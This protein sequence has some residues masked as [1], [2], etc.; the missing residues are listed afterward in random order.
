M[1]P[2]VPRL[3]YGEWSARNARLGDIHLEWAILAVKGVGGD[4]AILMGTCPRGE[5]PA[6]TY[7]CSADAG[8]YH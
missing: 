3:P 5:Y 4:H 8:G 6:T 1:E 2:G 7:D